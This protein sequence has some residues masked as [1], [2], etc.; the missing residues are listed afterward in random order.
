M[1]LL[2]DFFPI[3]LFFVVFKFYGIFAATATAIIATFAQVGYFW[4]KHR[5]V[6]KMH[7]VTLVLI[8]VFGG[9]T[10]LLEDEIFIK[11]KP[12]VLNWLFAV[13]FLGSQFIGKKT[14]TE[15]MMEKA[16][17]L[18]KNIWN[19]LNWSWVLF[20]TVLGVANIF[21]L[22]N[23]DTETWVNFKLFGM[24]GLT[25]LFVVLQSLV[26]ARFVKQVPSSH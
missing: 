10:L 24:M 6:E 1:K 19:R 2:F 3:L 4:F 13:A 26:L 25:V 21:V 22:Y 17:E 5:R 15:R 20:F 12:T 23:Y 14:L 8:T 11:W 16:I 9:A 7:L 18:P